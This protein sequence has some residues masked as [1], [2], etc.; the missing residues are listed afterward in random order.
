MKTR[1][2][3]MSN[4]QMDKFLAHLCD[5]LVDVVCSRGDNFILLL[6]D[7]DGDWH[8]SLC[9]FDK[10]KAVAALREAAAKFEREWVESN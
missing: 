4:E 2:D 5:K 6:V 9:S 3:E 8:G 7:A 10:V 1:F